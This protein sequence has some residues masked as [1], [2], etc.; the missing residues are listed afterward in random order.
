MRLPLGGRWNLQL[1]GDIGGFGIGSDIAVNV[2]PM[3]GYELSDN[4][5]LGF[6]YR[7]LYMDYQSGTGANRFAYDVL[8]HGPVVGAAFDF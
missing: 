2:W 5:Q 8:T 4:A 1:A 7:L 3:V 6:G